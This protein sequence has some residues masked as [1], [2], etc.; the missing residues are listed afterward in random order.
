MQNERL[1]LWSTASLRDCKTSV[2]ESPCHAAAR[3]VCR[4]T[5]GDRGCGRTGP[6]HVSDDDGPTVVADGK[7]VVEVA[8]HDRAFAR[9]PIAHRDVD[10]GNVG[11]LG[12]EEAALERLGDEVLML[13]QA[14][15]LDRDRDAGGDELGERQVVIGIAAHRVRE[16][17]LHGPEHP[18][19]FHDRYGDRRSQCQTLDDRPRLVIDVELIEHARV[20]V[21]IE[22]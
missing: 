7:H 12:W 11:Q 1:P 21:R 2:S 4:A 14:A 8:A 18:P 13:A 10:A 9:R 6:T 16:D 17:E 22:L 3:T 5:P 15:I 20:D 19:L